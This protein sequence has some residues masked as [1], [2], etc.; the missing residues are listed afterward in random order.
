[1]ARVVSRFLVVPGSVVFI[2][3]LRTVA[4]CK[5]RWRDLP[6]SSR[7]PYGRLRSQQTNTHHLKWSQLWS[8]IKSD[9]WLLV[10]AVM[11]S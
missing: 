3:G 1:M 2:H 6:P 11:V 5:S 9:V 10:V 8:F 4:L 7:H